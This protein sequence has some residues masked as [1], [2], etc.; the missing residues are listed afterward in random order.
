MKKT[1]FTLL[2]GLALLCSCE[3]NFS[4]DGMAMRFDIVPG[5]SIKESQLGS[6]KY[7]EAEFGELVNGRC[8]KRIAVYDCYKNRG[9]YYVIMGEED[10]KYTFNALEGCDGCG[11]D[12]RLINGDVLTIWC[13]SIG[14]ETMRLY[15][16]RFD[17]TKQYLVYSNK[18]YVAYVDEE[19]LITQDYLD[20]FWE[21]SLDAGA[22]FSRTVYQ[23]TD[24][25]DWFANDT[26][27]LRGI[28]FNPL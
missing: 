8:Y 3:K 4:D 26:V 11:R 19:Y 21:S 14:Y 22:T 20:V 25:A 6:N 9:T 10:G 23:Y 18:E 24:E 5:T 2:A 12:I 16:C 27:D 7:T 1:A 28:E 15:D 17:A 13:G